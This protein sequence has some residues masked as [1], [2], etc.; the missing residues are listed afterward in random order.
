LAIDFCNDRWAR[1]REAYDL[2]WDGNLRR[3]LIHMTLTGSDPGRSEPQLPFH[4]FTA[5]YDLSVSADQIVDVWDYHLSRLKFLGDGFPCIWP[6]FGPGVAAAF[7]GAKLVPMSETCW[8]L[9]PEPLELRDLNLNYAPGNVWLDRVKTL[10][11]AAVHRWEGSVQVGMTDLGGTLDILQSFRP[12]EGLLVDL[13]E[14][15]DEVKRATWEIHEAWWRYFAEINAVLQ[16][17]NPGYTAWTPILSAEPYYMLQCDFSYMLGPAMF[18]EFVKPELEASCRRLTNAFYHL[19]GCGQLANLDS[20]L[21]IEALKGVQWV[22]GDGQP[23][24]TEWPE[25]YRKIRDA[26]K[27]IQVWGGM[28][29]LDALVGQI[30]TAEGIVI[31]SEM[32]ISEEASARAFLEKY[33][34]L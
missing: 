11:A 9:P 14:N 7:L 5:F 15:P 33:G 1:V 16:P 25:V 4:H 13:C 17:A 26:G 32:H 10:C 23:G 20:L 34:A 8:F 3:P 30:G 27:L 29:T 19:D 21:E 18:D 12:G 31:F 24:F 22:P 6:N 2:W 28:E